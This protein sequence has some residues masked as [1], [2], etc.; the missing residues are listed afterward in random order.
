MALSSLILKV[1]GQDIHNVIEIKVDP[2]VELFCTIH[3]L[4]ETPQYTSNEF[5]ALT[6]PYLGQIK[7]GMLPEK[8]A[9]DIVSSDMREYSLTLPASHA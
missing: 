3:R 5:P 7:P 4:A 9:P 2:A 8:F 6:G 1:I